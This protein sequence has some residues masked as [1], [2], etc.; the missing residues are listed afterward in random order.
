MQ[1]PEVPVY[2]VEEQE[3][4]VHPPRAPLVYVTVPEYSLAQVHDPAVPV[5]P[6]EEH[7]IP[8]HPMICV[9]DWKFRLVYIALNYIFNL[10]N[11]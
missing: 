2:P 6:V 3:I 5:Y 9:V 11:M 4:A 7:E 10:Y 1:E 8:V